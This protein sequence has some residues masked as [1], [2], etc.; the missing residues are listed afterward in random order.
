MRHLSSTKDQPVEFLQK[1]EDRQYW[2]RRVTFPSLGKSMKFESVVA[3][4]TQQANP[5]V[6]CVREKL[7]R[8]GIRKEE[9][10]FYSDQIHAASDQLFRAVHPAAENHIQKKLSAVSTRGHTG[11]SSG[12]GISTA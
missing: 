9:E 12:E 6:F 11:A 5:E 2:F 7:F 3:S 8:V 4:C 1:I 10:E